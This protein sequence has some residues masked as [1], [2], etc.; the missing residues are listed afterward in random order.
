LRSIPP[1]S[2]QAI[3]RLW[4]SWWKGRSTPKWVEKASEKMKVS[5]IMLPPEWLPTSSTGRS[6][7]TLPRSRTSARK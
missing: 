1:A 5:T 2:G 4:A 3:A 6:A 7:G